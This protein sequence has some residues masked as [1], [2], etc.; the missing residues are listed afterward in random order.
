MSRARKS[1]WMIYPVLMLAIA[2]MTSCARIREQRQAKAVPMP[3]PVPE[4]PVTP[5]PAPEAPA[6][7]A[8][9]EPPETPEAGAEEGMA[10]WYGAEFDG[11]ETASGEI[12]DKEKMTAAHNSLPLGTVATVTDVETGKSVEVT[13]NDRG[14]NVDGRILDLSHAAARQLGL[15]EEGVAKV[16]IQPKN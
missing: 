2:L 9:P 1:R 8:R 10:S 12:Y 16:R 13:I 5:P 7:P 3:R 15:E 4:A 6:A 14:P 11:Q